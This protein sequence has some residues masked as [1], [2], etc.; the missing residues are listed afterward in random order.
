MGLFDKSKN[1][2]DESIYSVDSKDDLGIPNTKE[3]HVYTKCLTRKQQKVIK[4]ADKSPAYFAE[5]HYFRPSSL[6]ERFISLHT[7]EDIDGPLVAKMGSNRWMT[8]FHFSD[9]HGQEHQF[10][11][12]RESK[13][14]PYWY[15][16]ES[17]SGQKLFWKNTRQLDL[18]DES[19]RS[20]LKRALKLVDE[21]DNIVAMFIYTKWAKSKMGKFMINSQYVT[22]AEFEHGIIVTGLAI[23]E[24]SQ[25]AATNAASASAASSSAASAAVV[26]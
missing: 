18:E 20:K 3:F 16:W 9:V 13:L 17:P 21:K 15:S 19:K 25:I 10:E 23:L 2:S 7:G 22:S 6:K 26:V 4:H 24:V 1:H 14:A 11:K 12:F 8:K 5:F